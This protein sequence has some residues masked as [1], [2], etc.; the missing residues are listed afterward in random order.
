[1]EEDDQAAFRAYTRL[2]LLEMAE[3]EGVTVEP[4]PH[5]TY[6]EA[7]TYQSPE[8]PDWPEIHLSKMGFLWCMGGVEVPGMTYNCHWCYEGGGG[9]GFVKAVRALKDWQGNP[10][11]KPTGWAKEW[12]GRRG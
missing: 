12:D 7:F 3:L 9:H 1:M 8:H 4:L 6:G 11:T 5:E 10:D 2:R